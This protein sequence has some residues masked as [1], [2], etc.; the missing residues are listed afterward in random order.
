[1]PT[2]SNVRIVDITEYEVNAGFAV[3]AMAGKK[4]DAPQD[5]YPTVKIRI[6]GAYSDA[7]GRPW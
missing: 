7:Q 3:P 4:R 5:H 2:D 6:V 1:M